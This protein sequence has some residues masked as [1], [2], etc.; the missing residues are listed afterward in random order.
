M[1]TDPEIIHFGALLRCR[2]LVAPPPESRKNIAIIAMH[3]YGMTPEAMLRL[4]APAI[5]P[6]PVLLSAQGPFPFYTGDRPGAGEVV[7]HWGVRTQHEDAIAVHHE[8]TLNLVAETGRRFGI[9]P[10]RCILLGFSQPV[11]LNYRF[12]ATYPEAAGGVIGLCGGVPRDWEEP[13]Y[14][15]VQAPLLHIAREADEY[16]PLDTA[17]GFEARLRMRASDV[18]FHM[19]PGKHRFPSKAGTIIQSW[20]ARLAECRMDTMVNP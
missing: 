20:L 5:G 2:C 15:P 6:A 3:G 19:L 11:G 14:A 18:E 8:I 1:F 10:Q 13:K 16:F 12:I 7:Y 17:L 4:T 9:P